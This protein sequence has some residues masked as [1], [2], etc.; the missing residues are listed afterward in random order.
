MGGQTRLD[1]G[2]LLNSQSLLMTA[3]IDGNYGSSVPSHA[4]G[5]YHLLVCPGIGQAVAWPLC[6]K[7]KILQTPIPDRSMKNRNPVGAPKLRRGYRSL[8][9]MQLP[10]YDEMTSRTT[11]SIGE[12]SLRVKIRSM[13]CHQVSFHTC[14]KKKKTLFCKR[15][16]IPSL[17]RPH[18]VTSKPLI[19]PAAPPQYHPEWQE[20]V[21]RAVEQ[22]LAK[23]PLSADL[24][25]LL[26]LSQGRAPL[27]DLFQKVPQR[28]SSL[29]QGSIMSTTPTTELSDYAS[30]NTGRPHSRHTATTSI[31]SSARIDLYHKNGSSI[32]EDKGCT[33]EQYHGSPY[34]T[35]ADDEEIA[36]AGVT[37]PVFQSELVMSSIDHTQNDGIKEIDDFECLTSDY[38]DVDSFTEKRRQVLH[39]DEAKLFKEGGFGDISSNLPGIVHTRRPKNCQVCNILV[40]LRGGAGP[41]EPCHHTG[42]M[43]QKQ[44]LRALGYDYDSEESDTEREVAPARNRGRTKKLTV[45]S[46]GGLRNLKLVDDRI[47]EASEEENGE[48]NDAK[49]RLGLRRKSKVSSLNAGRI[50]VK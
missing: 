45:G 18:Y 9:D 33:A 17:G 8:N 42:S 14:R 3:M 28:Q 29:H 16:L 25:A 34:L 15:I 46:N 23:L 24:K 40:T 21:Q 12:W 35:P 38:S 37:V 44:R 47:D 7:K 4:A 36:A 43:T 49:A 27:D 39:E 11:T 41:T 22:S 48:G 26:E 32:H 10:F 1:T 5:R 30:S 2:F 6:M 19:V 20:A 31:D 50:F 13:T